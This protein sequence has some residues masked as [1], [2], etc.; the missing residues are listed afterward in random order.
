MQSGDG[1]MT[2]PEAE[3]KCRTE[4]EASAVVVACGA[5][6]TLDINTQIEACAID[7]SVSN[8]NY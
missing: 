7:L 1:A 4:I 2:K 5:K 8:I 6:V 3:Q